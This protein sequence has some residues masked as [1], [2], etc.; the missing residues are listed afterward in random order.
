M[1][2][3]PLD[4]VKIPSFQISDNYS[5]SQPSVFECPGGI[6]LFAF[7]NIE[8]EVV[9]I[10]FI[11]EAGSWNEIKPGVSY[12]T[13]KMLSNGTTTKSAYEIAEAF[14]FLGASF[15]ANSGYDFV[16]VAIYSLRK[17]LTSVLK[18]VADIF[19]NPSFDERELR[20]LKQN[21]IESLRLKNEVSH[22][23]ASKKIRSAVYG[24][25][26]PYGNYLEE[27]D[28][29]AIERSDLISYYSSNFALHSI[30][31]IGRLS[32]DDIQRIITQIPFS[33]KV[34]KSRNF[35]ISPEGSLKIEKLDSVQSSI[36]FAKRSSPKSC[37]V[38]HFNSV[39]FN[40]LLGGFFGSRLMKNIREQKGLTYGI[41][42][43]LTHFRHD[44]LW[45]IGAEVNLRNVEVA[46]EEIKKEIVRLSIETVPESELEIAKNSFIGSWHVENSTVFSTAEKFQALNLFGLPQNYYND[47][48]SYIH[49]LTPKQFL[50][51]ISE[52]FNAND[53]LEI[54]VG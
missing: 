33:K 4:R 14:D 35:N 18:I 36:R 28:V 17:N 42:S 52:E 26:H 49:N 7:Q 11:F 22:L 20:L 41:Y 12:F 50:E 6:K 32:D 27:T 1:Q 24:K 9:K 47:L 23:V 29:I 3:Q 45:L 5:I 51:N 44:S 40:Y 37:T 10:Q 54:Q 34:I 19:N 39:F 46:K 38:S 25:S 13:T 43:N 48:L 21:F 8:Q 30:Y 2:T 16:S 15:K 53:L 31:L